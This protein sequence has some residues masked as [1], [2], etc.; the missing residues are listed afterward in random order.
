MVART[1]TPGAANFGAQAAANA[2]G[3]ILRKDWVAAGGGRTRDDHRRA[4]GRV[5]AMDAPFIVGG[6][7]LMYPG[8]PRGSA[9]QVINCR[10]SVSHIVVD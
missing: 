9:E 10:C 7:R 5:V 6:D 8:D 1:G 3:L 2:T 4:G